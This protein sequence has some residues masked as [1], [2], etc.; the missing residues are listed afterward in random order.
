M[1]LIKV[2]TV[3]GDHADWRILA[4]RLKPGGAV[5]GSYSAEKNWKAAFSRNT[6]PIGRV[7]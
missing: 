1:H 5:M 3:A 7:C 6:I 4:C 2:R